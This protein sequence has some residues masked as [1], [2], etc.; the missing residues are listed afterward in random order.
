MAYQQK[1]GIP[2][3]TNC[4]LLMTDSFLFCYVRDFKSPSQILTSL[5]MITISLNIMKIYSPSITLNLR[6]KVEI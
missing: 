4:A 5:D 1:V 3:G 6:K 2:I